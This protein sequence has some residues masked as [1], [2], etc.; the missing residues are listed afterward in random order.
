MNFV[1]D[2]VGI[3]KIYQRGR[4][5]AHSRD[6]GEEFAPEELLRRIMKSESMKQFCGEIVIIIT[7]EGAGW[8][9]CAVRA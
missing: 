7:K 2:S 6:K 4:Q 3:R 9:R 1:M 8:T 5:K